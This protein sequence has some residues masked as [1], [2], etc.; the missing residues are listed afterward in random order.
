ERLY[1]IDEQGREVRVDAALLLL[2]RLLAGSGRKGLVALPVT[3]TS[4]ADRLLDES[5][6]EIVRTRASLSELTKAAAAPG[7]LFGGAV[8]GGYVWPECLPAYD[9]MASLCKLLELL[10]PLERP[11][12][13]LVAE[14]PTP[15]LLH[16]QVPCPWSLKGAV[17]RLLNE[18]LADRE[19]DLT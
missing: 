10:A 14:L 15:T 12:S 19:L 7:V 17:M 6:I 5:G 18:R 13:G 4:Q 1:L 3:V 11:L 2:L 9:A 16:R 8:G